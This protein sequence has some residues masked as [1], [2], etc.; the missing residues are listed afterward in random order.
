MEKGKE[1]KKA[2]FEMEGDIFTKFVM[3]KN[4]IVSCIQY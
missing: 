2:G 1:K 4:C 3:K